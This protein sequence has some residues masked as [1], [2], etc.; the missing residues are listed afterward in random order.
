MENNQ[1]YK[2]YK[3]KILNKIYGSKDNIENNNKAEDINSLVVLLNYCFYNKN[4]FFIEDFNKKNIYKVSITYNKLKS[5]ILSTD[6]ISDVWE[7][8]YGISEDN[9]K[10]IKFIIYRFISNYDKI[11]KLEENQKFCEIVNKKS[12]VNCLKYMEKYMNATE[13]SY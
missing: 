7:I 13:V 2:D 12:I 6:P 10:A 11:S 4:N 8:F 3:Q 5:N 1:I 9:I